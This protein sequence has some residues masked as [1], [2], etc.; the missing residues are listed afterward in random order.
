MEIMGQVSPIAYLTS[1]PPATHEPLLEDGWKWQHDAPHLA[2]WCT[3][4]PK[5]RHMTKVEVR[6]ELLEHGTFFVFHL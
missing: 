5:D 2:T 1:P 4:C 3:R 6:P